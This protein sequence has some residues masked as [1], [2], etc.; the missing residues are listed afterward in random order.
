[1]IWILFS[2]L[3][4]QKNIPEPNASFVHPLQNISIPDVEMAKPYVPP[5]INSSKTKHGSTIWLRKNAKLPLV[6]LSI[7]LKFHFEGRSQMEEN[8][9]IDPHDFA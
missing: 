8:H 2:C 7:V 6:N 9:M 1:M 4:A 5:E 3:S